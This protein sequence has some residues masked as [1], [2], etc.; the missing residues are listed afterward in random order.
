L[1]GFLQ[2][3]ASDDIAGLH[4][5]VRSDGLDVDLA[6]AQEEVLPKTIQMAFLLRQE[7]FND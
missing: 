1:R 6:R 4:K 2:D 5:R 7:L 3:L